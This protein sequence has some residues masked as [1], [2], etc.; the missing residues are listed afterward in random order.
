[1]RLK[2]LSH[3][4]IAHRFRIINLLEAVF[5]CQLAVRFQRV[6]KSVGQSTIEVPQ[7]ESIAHAL[8]L[9]PW[10]L[11]ASQL[12]IP[13]IKQWPVDGTGAKVGHVLVSGQSIDC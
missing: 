13:F 10:R 2:K 6:A 12:I 3:V 11:T 5:C 9:I 1:M 4:L 7:D 8:T